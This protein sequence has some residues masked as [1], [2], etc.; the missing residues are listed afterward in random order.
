M[1]QINVSIAVMAHPKRSS[2]AE[3]LYNELTRQK[4]YS[5]SL[6]YDDGPGEWE[7][8]KRSLLSHTDSDW[9]VVIQDDAII[10]RSFYQNVKNAIL[11]APQP[12]LLSFYTGTVRPKVD[13]TKIAIK[14]AIDNRASWIRSKDLY[15]GVCIALPTE[16]IDRVLES[17]KN[18]TCLYDRRVGW[19]YA[20][21]SLPVYY[22]VPSLVDHDYAIGSLLGHD[23]KSPR[24]AHWYQPGLVNK[25]NMKEVKL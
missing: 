21:H 8:G 7:T 10:S 11:H 16:Q 24:R 12:T 1:S 5:V 13:E 14:K 19:H 2:Y 25:W 17:A 15:W 6:I 18:K 4:F 20:K 9:H 23:P 22:S 3:S